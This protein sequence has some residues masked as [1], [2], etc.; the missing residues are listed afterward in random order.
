MTTRAGI[1]L[2]DLRK[3]GGLIRQPSSCLGVGAVGSYHLAGFLMVVPG[4]GSGNRVSMEGL[5]CLT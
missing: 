4:S 2:R 5:M 1:C 3:Q